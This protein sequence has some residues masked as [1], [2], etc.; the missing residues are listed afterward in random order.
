MSQILIINDL[1]GSGQVAGMITQSILTASHLKTAWLPTVILSHH[2][3]A[4]PVVRHELDDTYKKILEDWNQKNIIFSGIVT[5]YFSNPD[6]ILIVINYYKQ[7]DNKIPIIVD[8]IMADNGKFYSGFDERFLDPMRELC[9]LATLILPNITEACLL[10]GVSI[11][12]KITLDFIESLLFKLKSMG[13]KQ[14]I[15]TGVVLSDQS[16]KIGFY[17]LDQSDHLLGYCHQRENRG[18]FGTGD[19]STAIVSS[20]YFNGASIQQTLQ[21]LVQWLPIA[22]EKTEQQKEIDIYPMMVKLINYFGGE[23]NEKTK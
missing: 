6:Q 21:L 5:G 9:R 20:F 1:P 3:G 2:T 10:A 17:I 12:E 16:D 11:P 19:L 14:V 23:T 22:I 7:A 4:G 18:Y 15:L 8:P 13:I